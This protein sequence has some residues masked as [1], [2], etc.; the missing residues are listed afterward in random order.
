VDG[1]IRVVTVTL[2][3]GIA[4]LVDVRIVLVHWH[5]IPDF[6]RVIA[7]TIFTVGNG[8]EEIFFALLQTGEFTGGGGRIIG[9]T[10]G[11]VMADG[12]IAAR[13]TAIHVVTEKIGFTVGV[14]S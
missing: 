1:R 13:L 3:C 14:P 5:S 2:G 9:I 7:L 4:I 6:L 11:Y 8:G 10:A 12:I